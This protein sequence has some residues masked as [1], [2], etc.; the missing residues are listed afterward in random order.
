M[1]TKPNAD[2]PTLKTR[3]RILQY[4]RLTKNRLTD[5]E[6]MRDLGYDDL[7]TVRRRTSDLYRDGL[8]YIDTI[9]EENGH[10]NRVWRSVV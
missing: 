2:N 5:R 3:H 7:Y 6:L 1:K 4:L 10:P 9:V 8:I